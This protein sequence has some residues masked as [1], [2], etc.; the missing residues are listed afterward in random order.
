MDENKLIQLIQLLE[1]VA[2]IVTECPADPSQ[3]DLRK[4]A[5]QIRQAKDQLVQCEK[6]TSELRGETWGLLDYI[7]EG[8]SC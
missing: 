4:M 5:D 8:E 1:Q 6:L 3:A 2:S 7:R